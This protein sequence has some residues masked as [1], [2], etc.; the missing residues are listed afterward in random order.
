[1][2][3]LSNGWVVGALCVIAAGVVGYEVLGSRRSAA[4]P[5][6]PTGP[7]PVPPASAVV[8]A[9]GTPQGTNATPR[10]SLIDRGFIRTHLARW[11]ES[12]RRDP[13]LLFASRR[14]A[15]A[16]PSPLLKWRLQA[17][18]LQTGSRLATING[19][20]YGEGDIIGNYKVEAIERDQVRLRGPEGQ[21]TLGFTN[22]PPPAFAGVN[23]S[24]SLRPPATEAEQ[25]ANSEPG[26]A[27]RLK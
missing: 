15:V 16:A 22:A 10:V 14:P 24:A 2:K 18:W 23:E 21:E 17:V 26:A 7:T 27:P 25:Q 12:P 8:S 5:P 3:L 19:A 4:A 20:V 11:V 1:V 13:F 9:P 6:A